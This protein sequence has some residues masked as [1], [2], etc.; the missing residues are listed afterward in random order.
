MDGQ[1]YYF[2]VRQSIYAGVGL[3]LML[4]LSRFDY[5]RLRESS[6]GSTG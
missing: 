5:S 3:V 4:L 2:V 1:P 6:S